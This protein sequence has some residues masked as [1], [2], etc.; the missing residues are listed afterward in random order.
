MRSVHRLV[1]RLWKGSRARNFQV[2]GDSG[3]NALDVPLAFLVGVIAM[4]AGNGQ[5][6]DE[7]LVDGKH[8]PRQSG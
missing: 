8:K 3:Q 4:L 2:W 6:I 1:P 7:A 5:Q